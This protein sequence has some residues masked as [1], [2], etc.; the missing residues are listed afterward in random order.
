M[1]TI[2]IIIINTFNTSIIIDTINTNEQNLLK[3]NIKELILL[4]ILM[5]TTTLIIF[6]TIIIINKKIKSVKD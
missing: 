6:N 1:N 4:L 5:N 3:I 2:T